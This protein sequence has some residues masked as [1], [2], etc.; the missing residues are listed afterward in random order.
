MYEE[1]KAKEFQFVSHEK[2]TKLS[3]EEVTKILK[4]FSLNC[5]NNQ[6]GYLTIDKY[7][8][9]VDASIDYDLKADVSY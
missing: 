2:S 4:K 7:T 1:K 5:D 9:N 6:S 3:Q 8:N